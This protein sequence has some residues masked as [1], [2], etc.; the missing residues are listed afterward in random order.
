M[1]DLAIKILFDIF[2][3]SDKCISYYNYNNE[4]DNLENFE[5]IIRFDHAI[6]YLEKNNCITINDYGNTVKRMQSYIVAID[7]RGVIIN[8]KGKEKIKTL[9]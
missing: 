1:E 9:V 7:K 3:S 4:I 6:R 8:K 5:K 2:K